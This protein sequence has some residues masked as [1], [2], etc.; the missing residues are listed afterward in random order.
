MDE[1]R[2]NQYCML[3]RKGTGDC[4]VYDVHSKRADI[5]RINHRDMSLHTSS[6]RRSIIPAVSCNSIPLLLGVL[7][8][9]RI[10]ARLQTLPKDTKRIQKANDGGSML[11]QKSKSENNHRNQRYA[12]LSSLDQEI[13]VL[14]RKCKTYAR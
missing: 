12:E 11:A 9:G 2:K 5:A 10:N 14:S 8:N 1:Q 7:L 6:R 4:M 13:K 3:R